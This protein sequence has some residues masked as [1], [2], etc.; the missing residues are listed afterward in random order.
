MVGVCRAKTRF[1]LVHGLPVRFSI[2]L[3]IDR[4]IHPSIHRHI[5]L[6]ISISITITISISISISISITISISIVHHQ[7]VALVQ[8][9]LDDHRGDVREI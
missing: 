5:H 2:Y 1:G 9:H 7:T 6:S 8:H 4:S 3:S